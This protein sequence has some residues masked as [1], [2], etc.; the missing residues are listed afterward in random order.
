MPLVPW[1]ETW[2]AWQ[3]VSLV[4]MRSRPIGSAPFV[5]G[6]KSSAGPSWHGLVRCGGWPGLARGGIGGGSTARAARQQR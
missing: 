5:P 2:T 1:Q 3:A 4:V 6:G